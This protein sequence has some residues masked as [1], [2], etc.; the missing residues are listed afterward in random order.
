MPRAG[1]MEHH[2]ARTVILVTADTGVLTDKASASEGSGTTIGQAVTVDKKVGYSSDCGGISNG[3]H[4]DC[5]V[6]Q[7]DASA[8]S[9]SR[10]VRRPRRLIEYH[11]TH[12]KPHIVA[13]ADHS[14]EGA[15]PPPRR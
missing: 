15:T 8:A 11:F 7:D 6:A 5:G 9:V 2:I 1:Q 13:D 14:L 10:R 4:R 3:R 12:P